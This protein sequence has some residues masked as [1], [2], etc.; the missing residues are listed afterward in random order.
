M[1]PLIELGGRG[2]VVHLACANGFPPETYGPAL[3]PLAGRFRLVSVP[4]RALW[5]GIG[6]PPD[7]PGCWIELATDLLTGFEVHGLDHVV[8]IGHSFGAVATLLAAAEQP[9]RFRGLALLDPTVFSPD[10]MAVIEDIRR[11]GEEP[12]FALTEGAR[13]RKARFTTRSEAFAYWRDKSL[14][15]DWSDHI[16]EL[17][18]DAML[19]PDPAH[20]G[21]L[22]RWTPAWEAWYYR[23]FFTGTWEVLPRIPSRLPI[24]VAG[25]ARSDTFLAPA[26]ARFRELRPTADFVQLADAGHLFPHSAPEATAEILQQ[27]ISARVAPFA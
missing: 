4:P 9:G 3:A 27:W 6:D 7:E 5:P 21:F 23:S 15:A 17:Y 1:P 10:R 11:R 20:R 16:L 14:F 12:R 24:L 2:S 26:R 13:K 22:L 25:G 19:R 8:G 18:V